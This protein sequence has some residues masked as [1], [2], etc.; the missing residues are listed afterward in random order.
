[1]ILKYKYRLYPTKSQAEKLFNFCGANRYIWNHFLAEEIKQYQIDQKFRFYHNNSQDLTALKKTLTWLKD[2]PSTSLQQT[3]RNLDIALK[4]SF[5]RGNAKKGFPKFK[6][7][8]YFDQSFSLAM[9]NATNFKSKNRFLMPKI[10]QMKV[11]MHR[12]LPSDFASGQVKLEGNRWFLVLTCDS[13]VVSL[14]KTEKSIGIDL[15]SKEYVLSNGTR[16]IIPKF[17]KENQFQI[18]GLQR[19]LAKCKNGSTNRRKIQLKLYK[20][21]Q[22]VTNKRLNYFHTLSKNLVTA[23]DRISLESLDVAGIQGKMGK[24]VQD[25]GFSMFRSM[26]VYKAELYGKETVLIDRWY[27]SSQLCSQCRS[28]HKIELSCRTYECSN[29]KLII[30]RDLNAAININGAGT[31]QSAPGDDQVGQMI[32]FG[33]LSGVSDGGSHVL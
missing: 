18:K 12:N 33:I 22:R 3:L 28:L 17:L 1:M 29:C 25:N 14:P 10:G 7:K 11:A 24:V 4:Q 32:T 9:I 5:K 30:D 23:Y 31:A 6:K 26:I 16:H 27:P 15:N 13:P 8:K 19:K 2:V 20:V 21:H